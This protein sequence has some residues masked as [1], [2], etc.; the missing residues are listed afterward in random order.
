M[1]GTFL[2]AK[3]EDVSVGDAVFLMQKGLSIE[4]AVVKRTGRRIKLMPED[5]SGEMWAAP[6]E[7]TK[8]VKGGA[9]EL[10]SR[11]ARE[12]ERKAREEALRKAEQAR[13][14]AE[15]AE[16]A[17][18]EAL[19]KTRVDAITTQLNRRA[20]PSRDW[21][22]V[23]K[24]NWTE[25]PVLLDQTK[26]CYRIVWYEIDVDKDYG[27]K[28]DPPEIDL[29]EVDALIE[30]VEVRNKEREA[31]AKEVRLLAAAAVPAPTPNM[32]G[33]ETAPPPASAAP[34][35]TPQSG[36]RPT[37]RVCRRRHRRRSSHHRRSSLA[38][39]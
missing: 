6:E 2:P 26:D 10:M 33:D 22:P 21:C 30:A 31:A 8:V 29:S 15:A 35:A 19:Q 13:K 28:H 12:A 39:S 16:K 17:N 18:Y 20:V 7:C 36:R 24:Y 11:G 32:L 25:S 37:L 9:E 38:R 14:D 34:C 23:G 3:N 4:A 5:R 27:G 1:T